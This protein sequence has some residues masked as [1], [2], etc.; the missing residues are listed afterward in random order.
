MPARSPAPSKVI[1]SKYT[2]PGQDAPELCVAI[3]GLRANTTTL[4]LWHNFGREGRLISVELFEDSEGRQNGKARVK[5]APP[6]KQWFWYMGFYRFTTEDDTATYAVEVAF[7]NIHYKNMRAYE[8]QNWLVQSPTRHA[9][10]YPERMKLVP[11]ELYFG[12]MLNPTA[13]TIMHSAKQFGLKA[14]SIS[15]D[16]RRKLMVPELGIEISD[17]RPDSHTPTEFQELMVGKFNRIFDYKFEIK[18][19][20]IALVH[21]IPA[22]NGDFTLVITLNDPPRFFRRTPDVK[23]THQDHNKDNEAPTYNAMRYWT[24]QDTWM[25]QTDIVYYPDDLKRQPLSLS[26]ANPVVDIGAAFPKSG[27]FP[28]PS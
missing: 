17:P 13:M 18:F 21:R 12:F 23:A 14:M 24:E 19:S 11:N 4:D 27:N 16:F 26:P 20:H 22:K 25:R 15:F 8:D 3:K 7:E 5:Y 10:R 9:V 2:Y 6:P 1:A 28:M